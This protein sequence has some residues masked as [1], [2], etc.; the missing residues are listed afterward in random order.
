M[1]TKGQKV[2]THYKGTL[3]DGSVFDS[4][5]DRGEPLEFTVGAGQMIPGYDAAV[6][7]M[8]VGE[9]RAVRLD[10]SEA[11]GEYDENNVIEVPLSAIADSDKLKEGED[12]VMHHP[13]AGP[14]KIKVA[15]IENGNAYLDANHELAGQAL[16]FEIELLSAE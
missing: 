14:M 8:E 10:P 12:I 1:T 3:D 7:D 4:S 9:K 16:T 11:Y 6:L 15:K 5:Y 2:T 13:E